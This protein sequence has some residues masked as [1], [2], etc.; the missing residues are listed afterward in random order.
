MKVRIANR[1]KAEGYNKTRL[2]KFSEADVKYIQGTYDY[3]GINIYSTNMVKAIPEP[4]ITIHKPSRYGDIG[5]FDYVLNSWKNSTLE[6]LKVRTKS[7]CFVF[8][9]RSY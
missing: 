9:T 2:P 3:L 5:V 8:L 6:W 4:A 7:L 1:S